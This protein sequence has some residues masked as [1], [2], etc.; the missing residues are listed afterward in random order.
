MRSGAALVWGVCG[1][2]HCAQAGP[3]FSSCTE[4][5]GA[6][7]RGGQATPGRSD[8][9][10]SLGKAEKPQCSQ[11]LQRKAWSLSSGGCRARCQVAV[12]PSRALEANAP[13]RTHSSPSHRGPAR[14]RRGAVRRSG[15]L[16]AL[17]QPP[18]E[19]WHLNLAS[20]T[21]TQ[22]EKAKETHILERSQN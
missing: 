3:D 12:A 11:G 7:Y 1:D 20:Q 18:R 19:S 4:N 8:L 14:H 2:C 13:Q 9:C 6:G 10:F 5:T 21:N 17:Q 15:Y 16:E 22:Q